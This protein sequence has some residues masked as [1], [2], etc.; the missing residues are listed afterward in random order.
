MLIASTRSEAGKRG[1][2]AV[3]GVLPWPPLPVT[4]ISK[5]AM[6]AERVPSRTSTD[7]KGLSAST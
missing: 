5:V 7:P 2:L 4:V 3:W 1:L 6:A